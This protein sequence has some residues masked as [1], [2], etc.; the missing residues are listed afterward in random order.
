MAMMAAYVRVAQFMAFRGHFWPPRASTSALIHK[1]RN[2]CCSN[3]TKKTKENNENCLGSQIKKIEI[4][5]GDW[6]EFNTLCRSSIDIIC[7]I[8]KFN[9]VNNKCFLCSVSL[10]R[11]GDRPRYCNTTT[12]RRGNKGEVCATAPPQ[13]SE[14]LRRATQ[15]TSRATPSL[16]GLFLTLLTGSW[17]SVTDVISY[18]CY[19]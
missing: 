4:C 9:L 15:M 12:R 10:W 14:G 18:I 7:Q 2:M 1:T 8:S 6:L 13:P 17:P 3:V 19:C 5:I 11:M 16:P